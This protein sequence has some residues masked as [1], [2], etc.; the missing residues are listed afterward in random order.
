MDLPRNGRPVQYDAEFRNSVLNL[1]ETP[2]PA[3][4]AR[5]DGGSVAKALGVSD[6]AVWRLLR[7]E[8]ICLS[9]QRSWC[10]STDPEFTTKAAD[11]IGFS[12][13]AVRFG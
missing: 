4:Q 2:P 5:W 8:G 10:V 13:F 9:R 7:K 1:L 11:I 6:D 3:G 12:N